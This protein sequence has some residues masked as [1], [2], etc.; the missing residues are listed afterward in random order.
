MNTLIE[1]VEENRQQRSEGHPQ[2]WERY[3]AV[4]GWS[5]HKLKASPSAIILSKA[6]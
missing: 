2:I 1:R 3:I 4:A 5:F 6:F